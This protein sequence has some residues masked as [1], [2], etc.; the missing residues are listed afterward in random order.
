M[1]DKKS[2]FEKELKNKLALKS[3]GHKSEEMV[4]LQAFKYFDLDNTGKCSENEF[5]KAIM[6]IGITGFNEKDLSELFKIYDKD[7][8][9]YLD[10]KEFVGILYSNNSIM[11]ER[12]GNK[13]ENSNIKNNNNVNNYNYENNNN[14]I[15]QNE[16]E[17]LNEGE[18]ILEKIRKKLSARGVRGI[19]SI[20]KNFRLIV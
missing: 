20:A 9:G 10:Y 19:T 17:D 13:D 14:E 1:A 5:L 12:R 7:N 2:L 15:I 3:S 18:I 16:K 4:L 11:N 6:K 8:S